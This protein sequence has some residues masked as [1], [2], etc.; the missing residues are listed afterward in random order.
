L[1]A[2]WRQS[3]DVR[4]A[5]LRSALVHALDK[6]VAGV[7]ATSDPRLLAGAVLTSFLSWAVM[8]LCTYASFL[9]FGIEVPLH[10]AFVVIL[11]VSAAM[12]LPSAPGWIGAVQLGFTLGLAP[13]GIAAG[14]AFATSLVF[15]A[16]IYA[17]AL[18]AGLVFL[19]R[20]GWRLLELHAQAVATAPE[21]TGD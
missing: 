6:A 13:Y 1:P 7:K 19:H 8:G 14:D 20:I 21:G 3:S 11:L 15:H 12:I 5:R 2:A 4:G 10:A 9:A 16:T 18:I 17:T